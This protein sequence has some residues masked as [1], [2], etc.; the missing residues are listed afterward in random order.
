MYFLVITVPIHERHHHVIC[1]CEI[2][3][4]LISLPCNLGK[5]DCCGEE[6][7]AAL[8]MMTKKQRGEARQQNDLN[9]GEFFF[10]Y[11][12][13]INL[14]DKITHHHLELCK[15]FPICTVSTIPYFILHFIK[16]LC[17]NCSHFTL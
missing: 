11:Q 10:P 12:I 14:L 9:N 16:R 8:N 7:R 17:L 3:D 15:H 1:G 5:K 4:C 13:V 2:L 6:D